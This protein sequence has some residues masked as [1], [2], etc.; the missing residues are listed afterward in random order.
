MPEFSFIQFLSKLENGDKRFPVNFLFGFNEFLGEV[1]LEKF[2]D[3]F[4]EKRT[5]FNFKRFYFDDEGSIS[6][7]EIIEEAK[8]SSFFIQSRKILVATIRDQKKIF[9]TK[10]DLN[11]FSNYLADPNSDTI[12]VIYISLNLTPDAFKA[13]KRE[14]LT[15]IFKS[16]DPGK[17]NLVNLDK[18]SEREVKEYIKKYLSNRGIKISPSALEKII[19][20][21]GD[22][23]ISILHEL[24]KMEI[25]GGEEKNID[26]E[27]IEEIITG[28]EAHSIWE[29]TEAIEREDTD[30]YLKI[31]NFLFLN[32]IKPAIIIGT[33][34]AHY[35][36]IFIAKFMLRNNI[37]VNDV[38]R[39]LNQPGF[40]LQRFIALTRSFSAEKLKKIQKVIY[41]LDYES[42]TSGENSAKLLLE[43]FIF[44]IRS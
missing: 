28:I 15:R 24:N 44:Q 3:L 10:D 27:D 17:I 13:L 9:S 14:K 20:I 23:Y 33:L 5:E 16:L 26:S 4:L 35:N 6:W 7:Q 30:S 38:G 11:L 43:N 25:A 40:L 22:D 12:L 29:L 2:S 21:K 31:L 8:S 36:K 1:I 41:N 34:I 18:I 19:E 42:K 32:G 39:A 37:N